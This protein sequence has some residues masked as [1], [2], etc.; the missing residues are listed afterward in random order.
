M[1]NYYEEL[2]KKLEASCK[3]CKEDCNK[4]IYKFLC[5][6]YSDRATNN[7]DIYA[8]NNNS[9]IINGKDLNCI[10]GIELLTYT[11]CLS[12][13]D[14]LTGSE[15]IVINDHDVF[16]IDLSGY[17][18]YSA[19]VF[20]NKKHL[21]YAD[22]FQLHHKY[23]YPN[24]NYEERTEH[25]PET[26]KTLYIEYLSNK[27]FSEEQTTSATSYNEYRAKEY[28]LRNYWIQQFDYKSAFVISGTKEEKQLEKEIK[29]YKFFNNIS[30]CYMKEAE[31]IERQKQLINSLQ[32]NY[33]AIM[34]DPEK[35]RK[36]ISFELS[37]HEA[38][39]TMEYRDAV[40]A[41]GL[42]EKDLTP[43]QLTIVKQE[44][45]RQIENYN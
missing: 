9:Y 14:K 44:L 25:T 45:N 10:G 39:I 17:F 27:I 21:Y 7:N 43:E 23:Y 31:P 26:L 34:T 3:A 5:N 20:K 42:R 28:Y 33:N 38:C 36:A 37:N 12:L 6:S 1:K 4:C 35:F 19:L 13:M 22:D 11:E 16:L 32:S 8:G 18:G 15:K 24:D 2:E 30:Y 29:S 41:L 40:N